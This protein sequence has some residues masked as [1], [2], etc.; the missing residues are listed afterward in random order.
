MLENG[1]LRKILWLKKMED[2]GKLQKTA[3]R[4]AP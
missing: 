2:N 1:V 3:T 4:G